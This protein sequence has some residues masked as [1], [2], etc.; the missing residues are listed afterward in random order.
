MRWL[1]LVRFIVRIESKRWREGSEKYI[2]EE[3]NIYIFKVVNKVLIV[4]D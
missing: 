4:R 1:C 2:G 3:R